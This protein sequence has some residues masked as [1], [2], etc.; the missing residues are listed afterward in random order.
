[1]LAG[2]FVIGLLYRQ[3]LSRFIRAMRLSEQPAQLQDEDACRDRDGSHQRT[4][5]DD[6]GREAIIAAHRAHHHE[7][8]RCG[9]RGEVE[10]Q[11]TKLGTP[12]AH[13][14]CRTGGDQWNA[15]HLHQARLER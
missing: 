11:Y 5:G 3:A 8:G 2:A 1:M 6:I 15:D 13:Q 10:E 14:Y 4:D 7:T 9:W 12:K